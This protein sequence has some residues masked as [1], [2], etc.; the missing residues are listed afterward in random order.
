MPEML[1]PASL[2]V[3]IGFLPV[4]VWDVLDIVIVAYLL[5][6]LYKL[7]SGS[8][9]LNIFI[10]VITLYVLY[11]LV[12]LLRMDMLRAVLGQFVSV[13]V[14]LI[15]IIFQPEVRR[16]LVLLGDTTMQRRS[17]LLRRLLSFGRR[18]AGRPERR[19]ERKELSKAI[20][21]MAKRRTGA[22]IVV[23]D[24]VE[25]E[26]IGQSG[27]RLN[28]RLSDAL[29][30]TIFD[31]HTPLHDGAVMVE[32]GRIHSAGCVLPL[33]DRADLPQSLGL[34]HRAAVGLTERSRAT[35]FVVS[36]ESGA[37]SVARGG[38]IERRLTRD[39]LDEALATAFAVDPAIEE[40]V[41]GDGDAPQVAPS[42]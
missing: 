4:S 11:F 25:G 36:E 21:A 8:V 33:T 17:L 27:T 35:A 22:L 6:Q 19:R 1:S 15:I 5:Y 3:Q 30:R 34:R 26:P 29:L 39:K 38:R 20:L 10:G 40:P 28:A 9:A 41:D 23:T 13:G 31:K 12:G 16:F 42:A 24:N 7:L 2:L 14:I 37:I 18:A 32:D